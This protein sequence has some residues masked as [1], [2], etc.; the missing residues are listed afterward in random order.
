MES[1][2]KKRMRRRTGGGVRGLK[3]VR[4]HSISWRGK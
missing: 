1:E 2:E 3:E 4:D